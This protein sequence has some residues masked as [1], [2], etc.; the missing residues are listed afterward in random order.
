VRRKGRGSL[1]TRF[2]HP[3]PIE[4]PE[5]DPVQQFWPLPDDREI[6]KPENIVW[7][8]VRRNILP[9]QTQIVAT[10]R[11]WGLS[12]E[13][14]GS[15]EM[16]GIPTDASGRAIPRGLPMRVIHLKWS[17][18][19]SAKSGSIQLEQRGEPYIEK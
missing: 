12:G 6:A 11:M 15:I 9:S 4:E 10:F 19:L 16:T 8:K 7:D 1:A 18:D 13:G 3:I 17:F 2:R 14:S 5:V